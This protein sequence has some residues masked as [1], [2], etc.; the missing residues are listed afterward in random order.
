MISQP[1]LQIRGLTV[2]FG[3]VTA[4]DAADL[5]VDAQHIVTLVGPNGAGK[6]TLLNCI[7][8]FVRP[9][10]GSIIFNGK[11]ILPGRSDQRIQMGI[12]RT[13]QNVQLFGTMTVLENLLTAQ[14]AHLHG[15]V[16]TGI[17]PI[18]PAW[19]EDARART[20]A[21]ETLELLDL[22]RYAQSI[23]GTL[24]F[25]IQKMVGVARAMVVRPQLLLLDEPAAGVP[26]DGVA[27]LAAHLQRWRTEMGMTLLLIEHNMSLVQQVA[28]V[29]YVLDYGRMLASGDPR[30]VLSDPAVLEAY[31]GRE[32]APRIGENNAQD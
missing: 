20:L 8:G 4:I 3:G 24:P 14:H 26:H 32:G 17:L 21:M 10:S 31:L 5:S 27:E 18:G 30:T 22:G 13:F 15:N 6:T 23:S 12:G 7:S 29:V 1:L 9:V 2:Q 25:G 16:F 11:N 19:K 28:D